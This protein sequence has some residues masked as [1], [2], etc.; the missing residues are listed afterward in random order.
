MTV[1]QPVQ[2]VT[3][4]MLDIPDVEGSD[5]WVEIETTSPHCTYYFGP[6]DSDQEARDRCPGYLED[7]TAEGSHC[8]NILIKYCQPTALMV[9]HEPA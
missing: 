7:L 8:V 4:L 1:Q 3:Q 2:T 9:L 6:F 5:W